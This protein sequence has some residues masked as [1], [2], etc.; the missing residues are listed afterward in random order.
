MDKLTQL[1]HA[2]NDVLI[3]G[4]PLETK[5]EQLIFVMSQHQNCFNGIIIGWLDVR[6]KAPDIN[7]YIDIK[8]GNGT[9]V[10]ERLCTDSLLKIMR[11]KNAQ[12]KPSIH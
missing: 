3:S 1:R 2:I 9:Q 10:F 5:I 8:Y 6:V 11:Q 7:Q 12:W 4:V